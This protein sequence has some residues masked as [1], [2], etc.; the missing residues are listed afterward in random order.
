MSRCLFPHT[1]GSVHEARRFV[2]QA[3]ARTAPEAAETARLLVSE[4]ATNAL[5]HSSG[6]FE[7]L[8]VYSPKAHVVRVAVS[9]ASDGVPR[10]EHPGP[11]SEHGR[12]LQLVAAFS[13][14]W[15]VDRRRRRPGK[16]VW[17]ELGAHPASQGEAGRGRLARST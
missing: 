12:G 7:V 5:V 4:L 17:F 1:S 16:T 14:R 2:A 10:V 11:S 15:G 13:D 6:P 9:D 3:L 8:A